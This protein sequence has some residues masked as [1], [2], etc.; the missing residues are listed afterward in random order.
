MTR[1]GWQSHWTQTNDTPPTVCPHGY[2]WSN[3]KHTHHGRPAIEE[4][5]AWELR[6]FGSGLPTQHLQESGAL[7]PT[8]PAGCVKLSLTGDR[9]AQTS[10]CEMS[11]PSVLSIAANTNDSLFAICGTPL[12]TV[13]RSLRWLMTDLNSHSCCR[14]ID[15]E[16]KHK[17]AGKMDVQIPYNITFWPKKGFMWICLILQ[18]LFQAFS[19]ILHFLSYLFTRCWRLSQICTVI[20]SIYL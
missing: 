17:W 2:M 9:W 10:S 11:H 3:F 12:S 1:G 8:A 4:A 13:L 14:V 5:S 6:L 20:L 15:M 18:K 19:G 7:S 16:N